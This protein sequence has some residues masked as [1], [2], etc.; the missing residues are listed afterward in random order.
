MTHQEF[1]EQFL[2]MLAAWAAQRQRLSDEDIRAM[3]AIYTAA[4]IDV[5]VEVVKMALLRLVRTSKYMP[6]VAEFREAI[7]IELHGV[8]TTGGEAWGEVMS[9]MKRY[10]SHRTPGV[11]FTFD[12]PIT[13]QLV[14]AF[15][16]RDLCA[17][18]NPIA[19]R[20]RFIEA[21]NQISKTTRREAQASDGVVSRILDRTLEPKSL[22]ESIGNALEI[23]DLRNIEPD[24][25]VQ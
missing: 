19:D 3:A 8:Q 10:G 25:E 14:K 2:M 24:D 15:G 23:V 13:A 6:T 1:R 20:A 17:S 7:D 5:D 4:L 12:D 22:Q 9:K 16:W 21:Y 18:T 11:E